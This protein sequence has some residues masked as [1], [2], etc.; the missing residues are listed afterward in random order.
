MQLAYRLVGA[1]L[2]LV[3]LGVSAN[4]HGQ[5]MATDPAPAAKPVVKVAQA[6]LPAPT[7]PGEDAAIPKRWYGRSLLIAGSITA[8][9]TVA[10]V[11]MLASGE[12]EVARAGAY[13][14]GGSMLAHFITG[15][16]LHASHKGG[17]WR[18]WLSAGMRIGLGLGV[19]LAAIPI[20]KQ[21]EDICG[22][23]AVIAT[24]AAGSV[25]PLAIDLAIA[26]EPVPDAE[27]AHHERPLRTTRA[28]AVVV[29]PWAAPVDQ[30]AVA[31]VAGR[32]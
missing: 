7:A 14:G 9:Q 12:D 27:A 6:P 22:P 2:L 17:A 5:V 30:G 13:I 32:F 1:A 31:G 4:A 11:A 20:C 15:P 16:L 10:G 25:I 26:W 29:T 23:G 24:F 28:T 19:P 3:S 18:P 21:S 8:A